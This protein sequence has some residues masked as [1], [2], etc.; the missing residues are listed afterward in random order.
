[1]I[2]RAYR[3]GEQLGLSVWTEDEA[4]PYRTQPYQGKTWHPQGEPLK[5]PHEYFPN[6]T[7]KIITLFHPSNGNVRVKGVESTPNQVLHGWLEDRL[8]EIVAALPPAIHPDSAESDRP[9]T[10]PAQK[11]N[12]DRYAPAI[13]HPEQRAIDNSTLVQPW[14]RRAQ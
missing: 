2:E 8:S 6:G 9:S 1:M 5:Q 7:A 3:L 4:G 13:R 14:L 11:P 10:H 12:Q